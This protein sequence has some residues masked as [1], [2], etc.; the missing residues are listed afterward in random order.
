MNKVLNIMALGGG[1]TEYISFL[2]MGY[3]VVP[4]I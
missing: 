3:A 4:S 1:K 2:Y